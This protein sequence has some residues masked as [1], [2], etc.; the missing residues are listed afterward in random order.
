MQEKE[1]INKKEYKRKQK[2]WFLVELHEENWTF[3]ASVYYL[4]IRF[5]DYFMNQQE[6]R[7]RYTATAVFYHVLRGSEVPSQR[8]ERRLID[9][10]HHGK[11][12]FSSGIIQLRLIEKTLMLSSFKSVWRCYSSG[13]GRSGSGDI[14]CR[15]PF[16]SLLLNWVVMETWVKNPLKGIRKE[17]FDDGP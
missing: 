6:N 15:R 12:K 1:R 9:Q 14:T 10:M 13:F 2:G 8:K 4:Y 7:P 5:G 16:Q 17:E 11:P 3:V